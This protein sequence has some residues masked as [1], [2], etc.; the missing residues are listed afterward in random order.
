MSVSVSLTQLNGELRAAERAL[1]AATERRDTAEGDLWALVRRSGWD[2]VSSEEV[3]QARAELAEADRARTEAEAAVVDVRR[4]LEAAEQHEVRLR[5]VAD[6]LMAR[7][8][9]TRRTTLN[10]AAKPPSERAP[11]PR[12]SLFSRLFG[13]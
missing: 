9:A 3:A 12:R 7:G 6:V 1:E 10:G 2:Q 5:T 11:K 13:R 8:E 4:R